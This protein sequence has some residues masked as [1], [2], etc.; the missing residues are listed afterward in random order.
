MQMEI[1]YFSRK[2][3]VVEMIELI[4]NSFYSGTL[5]SSRDLHPTKF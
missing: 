5:Q 3:V 1:L 2:T 4:I